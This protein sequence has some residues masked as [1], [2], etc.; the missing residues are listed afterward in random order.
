MT[1]SMQ[2]QEIVL[3]MVQQVHT[4]SASSFMRWVLATP[5]SD[6]LVSRPPQTSLARRPPSHANRRSCKAH[7]ICLSIRGIECMMLTFQK[8]QAG[9]RPPRAAAF[10]QTCVS[11]PRHGPMPTATAQSY[12]LIQT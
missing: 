2:T 7:Y 5:W 11:P 6:S 8:V 1:R 12:Q 4:L 3:S 9:G 10:R